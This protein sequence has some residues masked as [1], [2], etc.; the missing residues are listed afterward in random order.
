[1]YAIFHTAFTFHIS[2]KFKENISSLF[3]EITSYSSVVDFWIF[4]GKKF[5]FWK[6]GILHS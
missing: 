1:M 6:G 2:L 4:T 3:Y 5:F